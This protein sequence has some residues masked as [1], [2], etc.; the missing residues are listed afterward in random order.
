MSFHGT[1]LPTSVLN[2]SSAIRGNPEACGATLTP[3]LVTHSGHRTII[4]LSYGL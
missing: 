4:G 2:N 1:K 3:P